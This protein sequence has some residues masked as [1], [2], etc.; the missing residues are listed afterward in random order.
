MGT[1][2]SYNLAQY[3]SFDDSPCPP[4]I[5]AK[6]CNLSG[7]RVYGAPHWIANLWGEVSLP[8]PL[9]DD[10]EV[11]LRTEYNHQSGSFLQAN[12]TNQSWQGAWG[13]VN[14]QLGVRLSEKAVDL[15][16]WAKNI[17]NVQYMTYQTS[18]NNANWAIF[19]D[20]R[21]V[22]ATVTARF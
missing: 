7:Q 6:V 15:S 19:S 1:A 17:T 10:S 4:E 21:S 3:R 22:G 14:A 12:N 20:P 11:Y 9:G 2:S 8:T 13:N 16:L 5:D 18:G